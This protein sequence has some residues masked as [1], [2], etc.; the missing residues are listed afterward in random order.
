MRIAIAAATTVLMTAAP[1]PAATLTTPIVYDIEPLLERQHPFPGTYA[2]PSRDT[3]ARPNLP[4]RAIG[5][6]GRNGKKPEV[7]DGDGDAAAE[8]TPPARSTLDTDRPDR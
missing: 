3:G 2:T 8:A 6:A 1:A 5:K 4:S 7:P